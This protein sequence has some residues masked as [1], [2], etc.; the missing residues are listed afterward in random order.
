MS[1]FK[2]LTGKCFIN[3]NANVIEKIR[4]SAT[5]NIQAN[6]L[7]K[8]WPQFKK[9]HK[10]EFLLY[11]G[12]NFAGI[13]EC[14]SL[15]LELEELELY[16]INNC[17]ENDVIK[18]IGSAK[19]LRN[20]HFDHLIISTKLLK[21]IIENLSELRTLTLRSCTGLSLKN[22][23]LICKLENLKELDISNCSGVSDDAL[24]LVG[25]L[26][27]LQVLRIVANFEITDEGLV[28]L[29]NLKELYC[30]GCRNLE[31]HGVI[32]LLKCTSDLQVLDVRKC[33]RIT[34]SV[35]DVAI[36]VTKLRTNNVLLDLHVNGTSINID[37][38][39]ENSPLLHLEY[40]ID[41]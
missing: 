25:E 28:G 37:K 22:I 15:C 1:N 9:F 23:K 5:G 18:L 16:K 12:I 27:K 26:G 39:K 31:D 40:E 6:C 34:N 10:L 32:N 36:Q 21:C 33:S 38:I 19:R 24:K 3:L 41:N 7:I 29:S 30:R 35:V 20:F 17:R 13:A 2:D 4:L 14:I 11:R 8:S